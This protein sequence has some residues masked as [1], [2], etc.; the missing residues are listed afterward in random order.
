M[1]LLIA[2]LGARHVAQRYSESH[3]LCVRHGYLHPAARGSAILRDELQ[4]RTAVAIWQ[5]DEAIR[6]QSWSTRHEPSVDVRRAVYD[7]LAR[8]DGRVFLGGPVPER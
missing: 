5:L 6:R 4:A 2:A 1:D 3:G 7:A 8:L